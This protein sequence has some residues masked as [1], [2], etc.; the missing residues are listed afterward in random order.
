MSIQYHS[1]DTKKKYLSILKSGFN[2]Y[3]YFTPHL[4][5]ALSYGGK[6]IFAIYFEKDP[7]NYWEWRNPEIIL[8]SCILYVK[9]YSYTVEFLNKDE[10]RRMHHSSLLENNPG[11]SICLEC[12]GLGENRKDKDRYRYVFK[13]GGG[14][15]RT[16]KE[17]CIIC[18][19]CNGHG[20]VQTK[21]TS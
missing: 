4:D 20:V 2:K 10:E 6:Y 13:I 12:D 14:S 9:K 1:T 21:I 15:F 18:E 5:T 11:K 3:T 16:R 17:H 8:P 7:T 19:N